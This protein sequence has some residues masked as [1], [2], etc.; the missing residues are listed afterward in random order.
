MKEVKI[1]LD[2]SN[3]PIWQTYDFN[4]DEWYTGIDVIDNNK[5]L[6]ELNN[7]IQEEY[8]SLYSFEN[9][10]CTFDQELFEEKKEYL[11][12]SIN[13]IIDILNQINDGS[14]TVIDE[15]TEFLR[16]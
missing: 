12:S 8:N 4:K 1:K 7:K 10:G 3:G 13:S 16:K 11:I 14:Y 5:K 6:M 2:F 9:G 15:E